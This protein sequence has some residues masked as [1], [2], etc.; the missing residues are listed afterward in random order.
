MERHRPAIESAPSADVFEQA[1]SDLLAEAVQLQRGD[2][3]VEPATIAAVDTID[4]E[5]TLLRSAPSLKHRA[6]VHFHAFASECMAR[7]FLL[8]CRVLESGS[9]QLVRLQLSKP[10]VL[11]PGDRFVLRHGSP[12]TTIGG[13]RVLDSRTV[14]HL[15]RDKT[16]IWLEQICHAD[17]NQRL[18]LRV[19]RRRTAGISIAGLTVET[20]LKQD[21]IRARLAPMIQDQR[22]LLI[23]GNLLLTRDAIGEATD[24]IVQE[25]ES[26]LQGSGA[27]GVKKSELRSRTRLRAEVFEHTVRLLEHERKIQGR[28]ELLFA[29]EVSPSRSTREQKRLS[30]IALAFETS[31][32]AAPSPASLAAE[33]GI[34]PS[35][36]RRLITILLRERTLIRLGDDSLCVHQLALAELKQKVQAMRGQTI[37][38]AG[39]KLLTGVSRKYAI[40]LLEYFDRERVT[41]KQGEQRVVL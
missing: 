35:E 4:A 30:A 2:T 27:Y 39:F 26:L 12:I 29:S 21:V 41:K 13:G 9:V 22:L 18:A 5:V 20:G 25:F 23:E 32:L 31:G 14:Q 40:P 15:N 37:D 17:L 24:M 1:V 11:L 34:D 7:L 36:M 3:L 38:V 19:L 6:S 16:R 10:I 8:G 33:L 28:N